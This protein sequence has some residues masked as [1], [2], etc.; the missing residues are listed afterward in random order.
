MSCGVLYV[1][2]DNPITVE[3]LFSESE[4]AYV[5]DA[6]VTV[7]LHHDTADGD[8][9]DGQ[10]WPL[11]LD[12]VVGSDGNYLGTLDAAIVAEEG[13][14]AVAVI[15]I[16]GAGLESHLEIVYR[17]AVRDEATVYWTSETELEDMFGTE[18]VRTWADLENEDD[19]ATIMR[20]KRWAIQWATDEARSHLAR[21]R[22]AGLD[23][24]PA[25]L[26]QATTRL[27]GVLLYESRGVQDADG[28]GNPQHRLR[29]H[30]AEAEKF[31]R[32]VKAD[33]VYLGTQEV[34]TH[35]TVHE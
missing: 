25:V 20:R 23:C 8:E 28:E 7:T 32:R 31:F 35:P 3:G 19:A 10:A 18:N 21:T 16:S 11:T 15:E 33:Q 4:N 30:R 9:Y 27:A 1:G 13:E 34:I 17:F 29:W 6:V 22:Y 12:Y 24:A 14:V 26:R 2:N 5:N